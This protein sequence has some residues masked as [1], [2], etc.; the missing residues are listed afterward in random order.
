MK[1]TTSLAAIIA[2]LT[3]STGNANEYVHDT[4]GSPT[5][6]EIKHIFSAANALA[7]YDDD[8][9]PHRTQTFYGQW[10]NQLPDTR[11]VHEIPVVYGISVSGGNFL[12]DTTRTHDVEEITRGGAWRDVQE[13]RD[14]TLDAINIDLFGDVRGL[15]V[16]DTSDFRTVDFWDAGEAAPVIQNTNNGI[17]GDAID[18]VIYKAN[19]ANWNAKRAN[20]ASAAGIALANSETVDEV[21][22]QRLVIERVLNEYDEVVPRIQDGEL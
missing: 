10:P 4:T 16:I 18:Y 12:A 17:V 15:E 1:M 14:M 22:N 6:Q 5:Q 20:G 21:F 8:E 2:A 7:T 9:L 19:T 13:N 11:E 3:I